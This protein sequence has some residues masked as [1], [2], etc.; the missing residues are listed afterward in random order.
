VE[1]V[2]ESFRE[3]LDEHELAVLIG[4]LDCLRARLNQDQ[5]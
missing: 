1:E 5:G 4:Y 3:V 2:D